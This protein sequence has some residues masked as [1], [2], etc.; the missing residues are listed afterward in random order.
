MRILIADDHAIVRKGIVSILRELFP[1][2]EMVET[3]NSEDLIKLALGGQWDLIISDLSMPGR[4]GLEIINDIK[5]H[6]P[7]VPVLALSIHPEETYGIRALRA[8]ASGFLNKDAPP[9]E[10]KKAINLI[11]Q[12]RRYITPGIAE[13]LAAGL[14][15]ES[16]KKGHELLSDR[17][18]EVMKLIASGESLLK[19]ADLLSIS[20]STVSSYRTRI[21]KKLQVQSNSELIRY[22]IL[23][24][25]TS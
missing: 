16:S 3:G 20:P 25:L 2:A 1:L 17:E 15:H 10:L 18:L 22:C 4:G 21:L 5:R 19:I 14:A 7:A 24:G 13:K 8:G 6:M 12:G 11:L 23:L 9:S